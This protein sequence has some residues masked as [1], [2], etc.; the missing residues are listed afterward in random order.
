MPTTATVSLSLSLA[1]WPAEQA[2]PGLLSQAFGVAF[3]GVG[4]GFHGVG[5]GLTDIGQYFCPSPLSSPAPPSPPCPD[6]TDTDNDTD[7]GDGDANLVLANGNGKPTVTTK[8]LSFSCASI[9]SATNNPLDDASGQIGGPRQ[10][11][12]SDAAAAE[13]LDATAEPVAT[14]LDEAEKASSA[15]IS[16]SL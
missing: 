5:F 15:P 14:K 6:R 2:A 9:T 10:G 8:I 12:K 11:P 1:S 16:S 13:K 3:R 4:K 7:D